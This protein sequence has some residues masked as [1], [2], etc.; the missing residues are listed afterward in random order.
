[1]SNMKR[2]EWIRMGYTEEGG[3][4]IKEKMHM[5]E[6]LVFKLI[7]LWLRHI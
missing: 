4:D 5:D 7:E 3:D 6:R 1:M 2:S